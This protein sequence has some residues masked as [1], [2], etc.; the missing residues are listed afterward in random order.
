MAVS[1]W[2]TG[3][4]EPTS[5]CYIQLGNL[6]GEPNC[7]LF[8]ALAG[9]QRSDLGS[10]LPGGQSNM[11]RKS[12]PDFE[13][14][15]AGSGPKRR[16]SK[17]APKPQLVAIPLLDVQAGAVGQDGGEFTDFD[18]ASTRASK[19]MEWKGRERVDLTVLNEVKEIE[20]FRTRQ[21]NAASSN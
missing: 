1:R 19:A 4:Q 9:L 16:R 10:L 17:G 6:A 2:E 3:K 12:W 15:H 14:V 11:P 7:W 20:V 18:S 8:C 21:T 5:R 13:I